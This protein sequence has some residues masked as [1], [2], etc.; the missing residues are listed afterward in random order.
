MHDV[1]ELEGTL[2]RKKLRDICKELIA[3]HESLRT[4]FHLIADE[5]VQKISPVN[6]TEFSIE[7]HDLT[8][9]LLNPGAV[10]DIN[11]R[12]LRPFDLARAPLFRVG[13][14]KIGEN[15]H[16][17]MAGMHHIISDGTSVNLFIRDFTK[18]YRGQELIPLRLQY[19][20][21]A[22]WQ[23]QE[24]GKD[25][26]KGQAEFW[27]KEFAGDVPRI[28]IPYDFPR[29]AV[30]DFIGE[31]FY[32]EMGETVT[33]ALKKR[34]Q[35][36]NV[37]LFMILM[38]IF[39][40]M[41]WKISG[42]EDIVVGTPTAGRRHEDLELIMGMFVNTLVLKTY[43]NPGKDRFFKDFL[44]QVKQK[45]LAA[46]ENQDFQFEDLVEI[47]QPDRDLGRNPLFD[48]LF[49]LQNMNPA[50]VEI[51]G[52][53]ITPFPFETHI[54]PLDMYLTAEECGDSLYFTVAYCTKL[55]KE[56]TIRRFMGY[57]KEILTRVAFTEDH[58]A[59]TEIDILS[60]GEKHQLLVEFN[61]IETIY[62]GDMTIHE[63]FAQQVERTPDVVAS[64]GQGA[65]LK[66]RPLDPQKT[67]GCLTYRQL[68]REANHLAHLL[69][70]K[71]VDRD[72]I[73]AVLMPRSIAMLVG[74]LGILK[75]G[76]A[77]LPVNPEYPA[78]RIFSILEDSGSRY[79]LTDSQT[80]QAL[81]FTVLRG[82]TKRDISPVITERRTQITD[83]DSLPHPDRTLV[84]YRKYH[85]FIGI[86]PA[87]YTVNIQATR[88]CPYHC[89]YCHKIWP[90]KHVVRSAGNIFAEI[91]ACYEAG[92][93][94]FVFIDDIFNLHKEN[95]AK[96]FETIIKHHYHVQFFFPNGLRGDI[97][98]PGFI[99]LMIEAGTV[100]I[101]LALET[102]SP[103]LQ[104]LIAKRLN[105]EKFADNIH[106]ITKKYPH[107]ILELEIMI[108]FPT[109]T[110]TEAMMSLD[111]LKC[112]K[113][114]HFPNLHILKIYPNTDMAQ[115]ALAHGITGESITRSAGL[116]FHELPETLPFSPDFAREYQ[117][118]LL[119]DYFLAKER[120]IHIF[121]Q[122]VKILS[123]DELVQKYDSYLPASIKCFQDILNSVGLAKEELGPIEFLPGD[124]KLMPM[125]APDF[126]E[127]IKAYPSRYSQNY[128]GSS[129]ANASFRVLLIDISQSFRL[130]NSAALYDVGAEPLGLMYLA[131][132]LHEQLGPV[133]QV[134]ILKSRIDFNSYEE[135]A[136][137]VC[138]FKPHLIGLRSLS[139]YKE[140]FHRTV[141]VLRHLGI[142]TPIIAGGPYATSDYK[143]LLQ[144]DDV[145]LAVLGEGELTLTHLVKE[146]MAHHH[147]LPAEE[148]LKTI[149]GL[150]Y[151][152]QQDKT[153]PLTAVSREV[154]LMDYISG[155]ANNF[156][157]DTT[158]NP[159]NF[160]RP[161]DLLYLI[162]TSGSTGLPKSVM[163]EHRTMV[164][165]MNYQF[166]CP[167]IHFSRVLQFAAIGFDVSLQEIFSALLSGGIVY[168]PD[169]D[170][171]SDVLRLF[172]FIARHK[173]NILFL[174]PAFLRFI[175]SEPAL[176]RE[177]P[178]S[179]R[180]IITA[181]EQLI[182]NEPLRQLL[183]E[184]HIYLH[185]H[186][187]PSETHV[188]TSLTIDPVGE[189]VEFPTIGKPVQNT[190]IYIVD[191][192]GNLLPTGAAGELLI[193]GL[194]VGRGY[195]NRP[196]LT[197]EK[198]RPQI[199]LMTQMALIKSKINKSF[200]GVKG[201]LFQ[202][203]PLATY[204][205]G[206][207]ARWLPDGPPAGGAAKGIIE[208]LGR[209]DQQVKIRGF[210]VE[211]GE[212][213]SRLAKYPGIKQVLVWVREEENRDKY[214]DAYIV[215]A[216]DIEVPKL[217]DYL[218]K[219]LP[220]YMIPS[221]FIQV[222]K[223]PLT[224]S[225]KVDYRR[226]PGPGTIKKDS[227]VGPRTGIEKKMA[228]LW[229]EV[230]GTDARN[231]LELQRSI[232]IDD[233][234]F[235]LGGHSLKATILISKLH[236]VFNVKIPLAEVFKHPNIRE[237]SKYIKDAAP[238]QYEP[239]E[240]TEKKEY[241]ALS[242][243]QRRLY[244]L[245]Q[246][247]KGSTA[248]HISSMMVVAGKVDKGQLERSIRELIQRHESLRTS[249]HMINDEPV[250]RIHEEV[251]FEIK[252][253]AADAGGV[254][255]QTRP[256]GGGHL[257]KFI[258]PFDLSQAPL[259]R[260]GLVKPGEE[261]QI[262][263]VDMH[264]II[265]DGWSLEVLKKEF[266]QVYEAK[267]KDLNFDLKP[268]QVQYK[269][270]AAWQNRLLGDEE[271]MG[272]AKISWKN[273]LNNAAPVMALP[274]DFPVDSLKTRESS[275]Y[276]FFI[277][278]EIAGSLG[279]LA[280]ERKGSLFI[281]LLA[282]FNI[283]LSQITYQ[284]NILVGIPAA[285]RQHPDLQ[286]IAGL[287]VNTLILQN[288]VN[289]GEIFSDFLERFQ[290]NTIHVLEYQEYPLEII[291]AELKIKY[292]EIP[293]FFNMLNIGSSSLEIISNVNMYHSED[294]R[295]AKFPIHCYLS[296]FKNGI[297]VECYYFRELFM[298][299]SI[300]KIMQ[301]YLRILE[302]IAASPMKK[303]KD[304][305]K[306][307]EKN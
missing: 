271:K 87:K 124:E 165:L 117:A 130:E 112:I 235:Q 159:K 126:N 99:D 64:G 136:D 46:F 213:E 97:L 211:P 297:Q 251:E 280:G 273:Y 93:K 246:K 218:A 304:L 249:F 302:N 170:M 200:A 30:Q 1:F 303:I 178:A 228:V 196:E 47:I 75:G 197:A 164:N 204:K 44:E 180:H 306:R 146:M 43:I 252:Y 291:F 27:L 184:R 106:Y 145:Q 55:F 65:F 101:A 186:Y 243:A 113:W 224:S 179:V 202:K 11:V 158:D 143:Q 50:A 253:L 76:G 201:E 203:L 138:L 247:D 300:E 285:A 277:P 31:K 157:T 152:R 226:L 108:G 120:L 96:L 40:V 237:L 57:F 270:Y 175:F 74:L 12:F 3:R 223:I 295:E 8:D 132:Y 265:S 199:T 176:A 264:H 238:W 111:F 95:S 294:T 177:F 259:M 28:A 216:Q 229:A 198:F 209:I 174:P 77:Y 6:E 155:Q 34:A 156:F 128:S 103:R 166:Q 53:K 94:R 25:K 15:R 220:D 225:G 153:A 102:A 92:V 39:N 72:S 233:N 275:A 19:K 69:R 119:D 171:R 109:E 121:R 255:G 172:D 212:I 105:L 58:L 85:R 61:G 221:F 23:Q 289:D 5:P 162:S 288:K 254:H 59:L 298:P 248:Y 9:E 60:A 185:N 140:F 13:L 73:V 135:L 114:I 150:A 123:E 2:D 189:I 10:N 82:M 49:A 279:L 78:Q 293:A 54:A 245:Q 142:T 191:K 219:E 206:D 18:L 16:I 250:Q 84:D 32:L 241:Y 192:W 45:S 37:T 52:L 81:T 182:V 137:E 269:D 4:S 107:V 274:Y 20:D 207:L 21:Y 147:Q 98:T 187:G 36:K 63:W 62:P 242:P 305:A 240:L 262:L 80:A 210:R 301:I 91:R 261:K 188:V 86:A 33:L 70:Q 268:L 281:V 296:E 160:N 89:A 278:G 267:K 38:A 149:P 56:D 205:T 276:S 299:A 148:I 110:E 272:Q 236:K 169:N 183:K 133:V 208:F 83:F 222:E 181:G 90:K 194:Q 266:F 193:G 190:G 283:L 257:L 173:I 258:R 217:R 68:N 79:L 234:F 17:L 115:L 284:D 35:E 239:I 195:L 29:P 127:K 67:F 292:P 230:L 256:P 141:S 42:S 116:A 22:H 227:Y 307:I 7:Y 71:G 290:T 215:S 118:R 161:G 260:V 129:R 263:M 66:N 167:G 151:I 14:I 139:I 144:D 100:N 163:V 131:T 125:A 24:K 104:K 287:F 282:A 26:K 41:L 286:N 154:L 214:I 122:Q 48:V 231:V 88:G 168:L 232:G 244:F 51:P 134:K